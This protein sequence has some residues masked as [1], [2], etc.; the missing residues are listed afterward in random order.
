MST[1]IR[2]Y[3]CDFGRT[4]MKHLEFIFLGGESI[5]F[6]WVDVA[7]D[8]VVAVQLSLCIVFYSRYSDQLTFIPGQRVAH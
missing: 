3:Y 6:F 5:F 8:E 1:G 7:D 2:Q 4:P